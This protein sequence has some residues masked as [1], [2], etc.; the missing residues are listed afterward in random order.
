M[1]GEQVITLTVVLSVHPRAS[2]QK[3]EIV[4]SPTELQWSVCVPS[5]PVSFGV[6]DLMATYL[7]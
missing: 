5:N 1:N 4:E 7:A 6:P 2:A 3:I